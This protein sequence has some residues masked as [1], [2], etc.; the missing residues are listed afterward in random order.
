MWTITRDYVFSAAHRLEGHPKCGR[1]HGHNY[2]VTV[3]LTSAELD[4]QGAWVMDYAQVDA[5]VK[6]LL[7]E[8][9]HRYV[10]SEENVLADCPYLAIA[11]AQ[12][13]VVMLPIKRSTAECLCEWLADEI[14]AAIRLMNL[15]QINVSVQVNESPKST[16]K[17]TRWMK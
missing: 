10:A 14:C 17:Y 1:L 13:H 4:S 8:L 7:E 15:D 6:P 9:D 16:A 11:V 5:V 2:V 12:Q 3:M